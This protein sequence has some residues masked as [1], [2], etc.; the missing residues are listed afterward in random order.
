MSRTQCKSAGSKVIS[1]QARSDIEENAARIPKMDNRV[2]ELQGESGVCYVSSPCNGL[3]LF[4]HLS[5]NVMRSK[6]F[7]MTRQRQ[8]L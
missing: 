5:M 3:L 8:R 7:S 6:S 4:M 1:T 2:S